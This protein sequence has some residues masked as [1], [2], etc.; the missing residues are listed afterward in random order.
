MP[1]K[2]KYDGKCPC[3]KHDLLPPC[4]I[5]NCLGRHVCRSGASDHVMTDKQCPNDH[6]DEKNYLKKFKA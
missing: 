4:K 2:C 3:L 6:V 5:K 1:D